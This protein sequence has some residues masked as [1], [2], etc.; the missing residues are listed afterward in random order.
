MCCLDVVLRTREANFL[1][2]NVYDPSVTVPRTFL[3]AVS[4]TVGAVRR[5]VQQP[6][7]MT[8]ART[9]CGVVHAPKHG[10]RT[11]RRGSGSP[12]RRP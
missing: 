12:P 7:A 9:G 11:A 3:R 1:H 4:R 2:V 5:A 6:D 8:P 10:S